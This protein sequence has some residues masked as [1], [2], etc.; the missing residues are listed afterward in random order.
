MIKQLIFLK[1]LVI[2]VCTVLHVVAQKQVPQYSNYA[3]FGSGYGNVTGDDMVRW[4][5]TMEY[6]TQGKACAITTTMSCE[7]AV[8]NKI[9]T[10]N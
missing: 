6:C 5:T 7:E 3:S 2:I 8:T 9:T 10:Q 4:L 1:I